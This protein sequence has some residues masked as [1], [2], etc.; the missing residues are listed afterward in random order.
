MTSERL[1][2]AQMQQLERQLVQTDDVRLYQRTLALLMWGRGS[3]VAE[4]ATLLNVRRQSVY[5]W[6]ATYL[7]SCDPACLRD[8]NRSGRPARWTA[9]TEARL[10]DLIVV[11]PDQLGYLAVNWTVPLLQSHLERDTHVHFSDDTI[12]RAL[13]RLGYVWKRY[14]YVLDPDPDLEKKTPH[15]WPNPGLTATQCG[16][17]GR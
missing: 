6:I 5:N 3:A 12:R 7:H 10:A 14:R 4:I 17:G 1:A 15:S 9:Q 11:S 13:H 16:I 2:P 8:G